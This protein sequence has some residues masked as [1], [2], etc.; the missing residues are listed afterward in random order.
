MKDKKP[1]LKFGWLRALIY[2][3][4]IIL[5][6]AGSSYIGPLLI[7]QIGIAPEK[8]GE[9]N[10][11]N[12]ALLYGLMG[13]LV[14]LFTFLI[15]TWVDKKSFKNLGFAWEGFG[16]EAALGLFVAGAL[17]GSGSLILVGLGYI[18][19]FSILMNTNTLLLALVVMIMVAFV[20]EVIFRGYLLNNLMQSMNKWLALIISAI[21][22]TLVHETN[23]DVTILARINIFLGGV[24]LGLNYIYTKNLWFS[25][26]FHF[27]WNFLQGP[28]LGYEVSGLKL[29]SLIQQS[30][31]GPEL[32]TGGSFGFEGSVL[33]PFILCLSIAGLAYGFSKKYK[34][35]ESTYKS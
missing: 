24:F 23:P 11:L 10:T 35:I 17:L 32:W 34:V 1:L 21:I 16:N 15:Y 2:F 19:F 33:C 29:Q 14:F 30:L 27:A 12:F 13:V 22:F 5:I 31:T 3:I 6:I 9:E 18:T 8:N 26:F 28:I 7:E 20:E 25:I 4:G